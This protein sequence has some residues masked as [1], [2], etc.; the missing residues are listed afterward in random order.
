[1]DPTPETD[2]AKQQILELRFPFNVYLNSET[3]GQNVLNQLTVTSDCAW[4]PSSS[5]S[6][7]YS[8]KTVVKI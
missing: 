7:V 3:Q 1:M 5:T 6:S 8:H 4:S 2:V